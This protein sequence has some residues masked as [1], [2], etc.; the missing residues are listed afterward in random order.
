MLIKERVASSPFFIKKLIPLLAALSGESVED[1]S[2]TPSVASSDLARPAPKP[3]LM[4]KP[5]VEG[6]AGSLDVSF[7][8]S[9]PGSP[10]RKIKGS[11]NPGELC[12]SS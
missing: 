8:Q 10:V 4:K 6:E 5:S 7:D 2:M 12:I 11:A 9:Y 1:G 3:T